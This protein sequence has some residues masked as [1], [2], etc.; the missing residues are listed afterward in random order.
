MVIQEELSATLDEPSDC[1]IMHRVEP[2]RLQLLALSYTEKL[3]Q[4]A[5]NNDQV[6][7]YSSHSHQRE[8]VDKPKNGIGMSY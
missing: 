4:L 3:N 1:L 2:S 7:I 6:G 8:S 5:D